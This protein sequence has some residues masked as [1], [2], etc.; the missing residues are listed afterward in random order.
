MASEGRSQEL[1]VFSSREMCGRK[2]FFFI[3]RGICTWVLSWVILLF[4]RNQGV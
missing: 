2:C 3:R 1:G 4:T